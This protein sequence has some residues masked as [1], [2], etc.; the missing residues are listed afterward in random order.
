LAFSGPSRSDGL[1]PA[2]NFALAAE[3]NANEKTIQTAVGAYNA[4]PPFNCA[5]SG[6]EIGTEVVGSAA[7]DVEPGDVA[8]YANGIEAMKLIENED[9]TSWP[10]GT[11]P[12]Y[13]LSLSASAAGDVSI[14]VPATSAVPVSYNAETA[15]TGCNSL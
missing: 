1:S 7:G 11:A 3:C 2:Q 6:C 4:D 5:G 8:S 10:T 14:Y 13:A 12:Y 15:T 9:L